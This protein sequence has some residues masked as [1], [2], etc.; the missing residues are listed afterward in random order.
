M[1]S[2][3]HFR[4]FRI[5][6][7]IYLCLGAFSLLSGTAALFAGTEANQE[8][9]LGLVVVGAIMTVC[10]IGA[11]NASRSAFILLLLLMGS[12]PF[13][14]GWAVGTVVITALHA[15][16]LAFG[17]WH[18][19]AYWR[20]Q[21]PQG[22]PVRGNGVLRWAVAG[23]M[24]PVCLGL[25]VLMVWH[26]NSEIDVEMVAG[27]D[28]PPAHLDWMIEQKFL[29]RSELP[30]YFYS[31]AIASIRED[32][33]LL[34]DKFVGG[35]HVDDDGELVSSW[36][37]LGEVC[38]VEQRT[39][40]DW[41]TPAYYVF[42]E[43][44][45]TDPSAEIFLPVS[46]NAPAR[47]LERFNRLNSR[48]QDREVADACRENRA[49]DW[50]RVAANNGIH[51]RV[52]PGDAVTKSQRHWLL[53]EQY[54]LPEETISLFYS[55]GTYSIAK[56]GSMLTDR[57]FGGWLETH[58]QRDSQWFRLGEICSLTEADPTD[59]DEAP[60]SVSYTATDAEENWLTFVLSTK[61]N[62]HLRMIDSVLTAN[63]DAQTEAQLAAC[64]AK[65]TVTASSAPG[66]GTSAVSSEAE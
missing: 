30:I 66:G 42:Y 24:A 10:A 62:G 20:A 12:G 51:D 8:L 43:A 14:G 40:G 29:F 21:K 39:E 15:G 60:S 38:R 1:D 27:S 57:F 23:L 26:Q 16:A 34:T 41:L 6:A 17:T 9:Y 59:E 63:L 28:I 19:F 50:S 13:V 5:I 54:L 44:G 31:D 47:F 55:Y 52:V 48:H 3:E 11:Y 56:G 61:D 2:T 64:Q 49:I 36:V 65:R 25:V 32:G 35:W 58:G 4:R 18:A 7:I 53:G 37:A 46:Q 22:L 33:N 45:E